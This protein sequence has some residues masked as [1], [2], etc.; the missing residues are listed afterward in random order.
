MSGH[1]HNHAHSENSC[2]QHHAHD[3]DHLQSASRVPADHGHTHEVP[4][5]QLRFPLQIYHYSVIEKF[6][7]NLN[8]SLC[9]PTTNSTWTLLVNISRAHR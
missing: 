7:Q 2:E 8:S 5:L 3:H 6:A 9:K 4:V 1:D